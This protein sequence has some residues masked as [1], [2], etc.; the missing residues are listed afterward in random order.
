MKLENEGTIQ[1]KEMVEP[2]LKGRRAKIWEICRGIWGYTMTQ[3]VEAL[4]YKLEGR[5]F[6]SR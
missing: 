6:D 1:G 2:S 3:L 5:G 4:R